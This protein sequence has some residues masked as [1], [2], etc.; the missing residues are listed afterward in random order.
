MTVLNSIRVADY[1]TRRLIT[2]SPTQT[3]NQA[4]KLLLENG[5]SGA[6]VVDDGDLVGVLC[7]GPE[8]EGVDV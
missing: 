8:V 2:L 3:V 4:I 6:P 7:D 1:M 5:I